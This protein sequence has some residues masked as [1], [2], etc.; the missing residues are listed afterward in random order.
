MP[1]LMM[2]ICKG[3]CISQSPV[4]LI[5]GLFFTVLSL[6]GC[7]HLP[8]QNDAN[9]SWHL[10]GQSENRLLLIEENRP[11][12]AVLEHSYNL[13]SQL[14]LSSGATYSGF[15]HQGKKDNLG[16]LVSPQNASLYLGHFAEDR[17]NGFGILVS[18]HSEYRGDWQQGTPNGYGILKSLS[19]NGQNRFYAG[20]F[21]NGLRWGEGF[22]SNGQG[23]YYQGSWS[24]DVPS[25]FGEKANALG[26]WFQGGWS[27]GKRNGYGRSLEETGTAYEGTWRRG[28]REG[29]GIETY[30]DGSR[31]AGDWQEDLKAGYG[32]AVLNNGIK[33][34]GQWFD[35]KPWGKGTRT[36]PSGYSLTGAW[37]GDL[38]LNGR[39]HLKDNPDLE[40]EGPIQTEGNTGTEP[41]RKLLAWLEGLAKKSSIG[42][43][44]FL[45]RLINQNGANEKSL[46]WLKKIA[47]HSPEA[48]FIL[49][50]SYLR[51]ENSS[52]VLKEQAIEMLE[53]AASQDYPSAYL[54]LGNLYYR[55]EHLA[56][57]DQMA[58]LYFDKAFKRGN[59]NARNNL[60]WLL[61]TSNDFEVRQ[62]RR[63]LLLIWPMVAGY[64]SAQHFDTLAAVYGELQH[65]NLAVGFQEKA[66]SILTKQEQEIPADMYRRLAQYQQGNPWRE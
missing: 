47:D 28:M 45:V 14:N 62:G 46:P 29:Y 54:E 13:G 15:W 18:D 32:V 39:V 36:F 25:G 43:Q 16:I 61:A 4:L 60:A 49:A 2:I 57:D 10:E 22:N 5:Q 34:E 44:S 6:S 38:I 56:K 65:F 3:Q 55:S 12:A 52:P 7:N 20:H 19:S 35:D 17:R 1:V 50:R 42:A 9:A 66:L 8:K 11:E 27:A 40:Y 21:L 53:R 51:D 59:I 48:A 31:Y 30:I 37:A 23:G 63:A 64:P 41:H 58:A 33:H 26:V 24:E